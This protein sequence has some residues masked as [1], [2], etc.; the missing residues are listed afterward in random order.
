[1]N[2]KIPTTHHSFGC[3]KKNKHILLWNHKFRLEHDLRRNSNAFN[4]YTHSH[5]L[6]VNIKPTFV[7][8]EKQK[9]NIRISLKYFRFKARNLLFAYFE[10]SLVYNA[11]T[12]ALNAWTES[13]RLKMRRCYCSVFSILNEMYLNKW[14]FLSS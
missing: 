2:P 11:I 1:M 10:E 9:K 4:T 6:V 13:L 8:M 7:R 12:Y 3:K 14:F 5:T